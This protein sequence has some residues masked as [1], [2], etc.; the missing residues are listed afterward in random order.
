M[1]WWKLRIPHDLGNQNPYR[2]SFPCNVLGE[3][4][5][6]LW[7]SRSSTSRMEWHV[8]SRTLPNLPLLDTGLQSAGKRW[9]LM[10]CG[11][12]FP[13]SSFCVPVISS[14]SYNSRSK[15]RL[16]NGYGMSNP[17]RINDH[18]SMRGYPWLS[19]IG[20]A[21]RRK[22]NPFSLYNP[23]WYITFMHWKPNKEHTHTVSLYWKEV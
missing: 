19:R 15:Q 7:Q 10:P 18:V 22:T 17:S 20:M 5:R 6:P 16:W 3:F 21:T 4:H 23:I 12:Q 13:L 9:M 8:G 2:Y 11:W 1:D 14:I